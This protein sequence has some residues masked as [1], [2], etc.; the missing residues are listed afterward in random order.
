MIAASACGSSA[1]FAQSGVGVS[2]GPVSTEA[3]SELF[4]P[5][6]IRRFSP[7]R[8]APGEHG[9]FEYD[10]VS[11]LRP[12]L[13]VD[14][15]VGAGTAFVAMCQSAREEAVDVLLYGV[16]AFADDAAKAEDDETRWESLNNFLHT[17]YRGSSYLLRSP[18][19]DTVIHFAD[20]SVDVLRI[21]AARVEATLDAVLA[22]WVSKVAPGGVLLVRAEEAVARAAV[23]SHRD[24]FPVPGVAL[25]GPPPFVAFRKPRSSGM[26]EGPLLSALASPADA[27]RDSLRG[28]YEHVARHHALRVEVGEHRLELHRKK[29]GA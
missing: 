12:R 19:A 13:V 28:F 27:E 11:A 2:S 8:A 9:A 24:S 4:V 5:P 16:D 23:L 6:S 10:L 20:G 29:A 1:E 17:H 14:L 3:T 7:K 15:G 25:P 18:P 22:A 21:D 26:A